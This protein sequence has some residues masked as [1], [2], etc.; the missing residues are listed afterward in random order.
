LPALPEPARAALPVKD[1]RRL[2]TLVTEPGILQP[3]KQHPGY[4]QGCRSNRSP[5]RYNPDCIS[6]TSSNLRHAV[7]SS[8]NSVFGG[9][10]NYSANGEHGH[11]IRVQSDE[12]LGLTR[13]SGN[14]SQFPDP[15]GIPHDFKGLAIVE[16]HVGG[17]EQGDRCSRACQWRHPSGFDNADRPLNVVRQ[18]G[19]APY[20]ILRDS[21]P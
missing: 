20:L 8:E 6:V 2:K 4:R 1:W 10:D 17:R 13:L 21:I 5:G 3:I 15:V 18:G 11:S 19:P 12:T 7:C 14:L 16:P 9:H